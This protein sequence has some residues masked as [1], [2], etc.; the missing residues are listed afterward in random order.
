MNAWINQM[1]VLTGIHNRID[2]S[3]LNISQVLQ[4][5]GFPWIMAALVFFAIAAYENSHQKH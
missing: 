5:T 2:F 1:A 3:S 4:E